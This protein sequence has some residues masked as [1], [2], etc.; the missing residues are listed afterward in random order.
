MNTVDL[1]V[2]IILGLNA[3]LGFFRGFARQSLRLAGAILGVTAAC[4]FYDLAGER[5]KE[6]FGLAD[7]GATSIK[8]LG[9]AVVG[10]GVFLL[11]Q[12]A[13]HL[14]AAGLEK[15]RLGG[16]DRFLGMLYGAVK[17]GAICVLLFAVADVVVAR[18]PQEFRT[19]FE[20]EA[21]GDPAPSQAYKFFQQ[22]AKPTVDASRQRVMEHAQR[23]EGR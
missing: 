9:F 7:W 17:G 12:L 11:G 16:A 23:A 14:A 15:A 10:V 18:L 20:G 6:W 19:T 1:V 3:L 22:Y 5:L 13:A 2:L 21:D 8:A 4:G